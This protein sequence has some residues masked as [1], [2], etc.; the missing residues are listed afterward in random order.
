M[1]RFRFTRPALVLSIVAIAGC[2]QPTP[3]RVVVVQEPPYPIVVVP[4]QPPPE[5]TERRG[6]APSQAYAWVPGHWSRKKGRWE[7][8]EGRYV[9]RPRPELTW[10]PGLWVQHPR[11]WVWIEGYWTRM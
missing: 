6:P 3:H 9:P 7:W 10:V 8:R 4:D 11:G 5:R 2:A 1:F